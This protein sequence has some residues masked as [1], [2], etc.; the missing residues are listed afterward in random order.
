MFPELTAEVPYLAECKMR[1]RN[2]LQL[3]IELP[4]TLQQILTN[5]RRYL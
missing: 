4:S 2:V 1:D 5:P 3:D